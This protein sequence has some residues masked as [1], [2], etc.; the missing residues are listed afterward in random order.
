[1][2]MQQAVL[3]TGSSSGFGR[4]TAEALARKGHTVF[5]SMRGI[6]SR[7]AA[8]ASELTHLAQR[9]GLKLHVVELDVGEEA[10]VRAGVAR[11][12]ELGGR[13]DVVLNNAGVMAAGFD[14][15]YTEEQFR[16]VFDTNV[17]GPQRVTRE[18][19]PHMRERGSGLVLFVSSG[20][21]QLIFPFAGLYVASK[22]AMEGLAESYRYQLAPLGIDVA[23]LE[24]GGYLTEIYSK[25]VIPADTAHVASY[26][27]LADM[28]QKFFGEFIEALK[29]P[30]APHPREVADAL[31]SLIEAPVG[32][33]P[34]RT[35]VDPRLGQPVQAINDA[36]SAV[37]KSAFSALGLQDMLSVKPR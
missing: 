30:D 23:I 9:E 17:F 14:E 15:A 18:V 19:L 4:L 28:P 2:S 31:V 13:I 35:V 24:P 37:Q 26:G 34:L 25:P 3:I 16:S 7:N 20:M 32:Q 5:A 29:A 8:A 22:R 6:T 1:M 10:S 11:A 33:R 27:P 12:L 21:A 36:V